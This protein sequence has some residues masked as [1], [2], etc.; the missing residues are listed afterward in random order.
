MVLQ[1]AGHPALSDAPRKDREETETGARQLANDQVQPLTRSSCGRLI[2]TTACR[3]K[4]PLVVNGV[5]IDKKPKHFET[6]L[7]FSSTMQGVCSDQ[8]QAQNKHSREAKGMRR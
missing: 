2:A 3:G 5:A 6:R 8:V 4:T 7:A 1:Q